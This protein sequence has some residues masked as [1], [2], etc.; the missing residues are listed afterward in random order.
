LANWL[1]R[2]GKRLDINA[3]V[4]HKYQGYYRDASAEDRALLDYGWL[5]VLAR[6]L[7]G[8]PMD[9]ISGGKGGHGAD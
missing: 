3:W 6:K 4:K 9:R 1:F 7:G 2:T 5:E 8:R